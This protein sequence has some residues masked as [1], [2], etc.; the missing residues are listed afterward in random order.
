MRLAL[1]LSVAALSASAAVAQIAGAPE[2]VRE[3]TLVGSPALNV[4]G[5]HSAAPLEDIHGQV[6]GFAGSFKLDAN[7]PESFAGAFTVKVEQMSSGIPL[8]DEHMRSEGWL[9]AKKHPEISLKVE[10]FKQKEAKGGVITGEL[11]G[12]ITL[13][14]VTKPISIPTTLNYLVESDKT[15]KLAPGN[16]V[17]IKSSFSVSLKD[18]GIAVG[19]AAV[20][21]KVSEQIKLDVSCIASDVPPAPPVTRD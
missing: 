3:F 17:R 15:K 16:L 4:I 2:G 21:E 12:E 10:S 6:Q 18:H 9:N 14:G 20:G 11:V 1:S 13:H 7:K 19:N 5:F 8:R